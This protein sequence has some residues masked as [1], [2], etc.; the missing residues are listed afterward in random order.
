[1]TY[2]HVG[3]SGWCIPCHFG[4]H[5]SPQ[6]FLGRSR[7]AAEHTFDVQALPTVVEETFHRQRELPP[8]A[9]FR[10][11]EGPFI[12]R[13]RFRFRQE[14]TELAYELREA[15]DKFR[16]SPCQA[17]LGSSTPRRTAVC[18]TDYTCRARAHSFD[19]FGTRIDL[20]NVNTRAEI[21]RHSCT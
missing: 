18:H 8:P 20:L 2:L 5:P 14:P 1:M 21:L 17:T 7:S 11:V 19:G 16:L 4:D 9:P 12:E 10:S 3:R 13:P 6:Y 15:G